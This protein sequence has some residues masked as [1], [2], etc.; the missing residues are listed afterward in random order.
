MNAVFSGGEKTKKF[1]RKA[2]SNASADA[3]AG[4]SRYARVKRGM[5]QC[6][7]MRGR[8]DFE[9][10]YHRRRR[11]RRQKTF[12]RKVIL[13]IL[14]IAG[15]VFLAY[16]ITN[17][18]LE[19][20]SM[21]GDSMKPALSDGESL[22]INKFAYLLRGPKRNDVIVIKQ[23]G[24]EHDYYSIKRVIALPGET[25]QIVDGTVYID[26][27]PLDEAINCEKILIPGLARE[28]LTLEENEYFV[29]GDNRNNSEDSRFANIG[30]IVADSIVGRA[31]LRLS[32]FG[33]VS[34][35]NLRSDK[36]QK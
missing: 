3:V 16:F 27:K 32:P 4:R 10:D 23:S 8:M 2:P 20:T 5:P 12:L 7:G 19:K 36:E 29:L 9:I 30:T 17:I 11:R 26:G 22:I 28:A 1:E 31:W 33:I 35:L 21:P 6:G 13:W 24:R 34:K 14:Q 25:V 15:V 18:M